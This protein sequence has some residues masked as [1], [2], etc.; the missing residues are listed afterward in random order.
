MW[1]SDRVP[2]QEQTLLTLLKHACWV[3]KTPLHV[4]QFMFPGVFAGQFPTRHK[5][6]TQQR[7]FHGKK[8]SIG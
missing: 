8:L 6:V 3:K 5:D 7:C 2:E 4:S 1:Q